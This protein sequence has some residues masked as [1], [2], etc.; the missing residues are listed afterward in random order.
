M[1]EVVHSGLGKH[2]CESVF[3]KWW[4][5]VARWTLISAVLLLSIGVLLN[6]AA[7]PPLSEGNGFTKLHYVQS[8]VAFGVL[9]LIMMVVISTVDSIGI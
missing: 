3:P 2:T 4:H 7:S 9:T 1:T 8:Q 5:T 6:F